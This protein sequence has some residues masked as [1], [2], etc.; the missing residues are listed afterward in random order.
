MRIGIASKNEKGE[1]VLGYIDGGFE[2]LV[3]R[4]AE[5]IKKNNGEIKLNS[6]VKNIKDLE[7]L[8]ISY[9]FQ[10]PV[11]LKD[12]ALIE[13]SFDIQNKK[14]ALVYIKNEKGF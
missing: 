7:N 4:L 10:T 6:E 14:E 8:I 5:L 9:N 1:E 2:I 11:Y 3:E 13:K 12:I